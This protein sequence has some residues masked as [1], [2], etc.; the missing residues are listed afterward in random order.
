MWDPLV[1]ALFIWI[2]NLSEYVSQVMT[3][4]RWIYCQFFLSNRLWVLV[5]TLWC[6]YHIEFTVLFRCSVCVLTY[7]RQKIYKRY[8]SRLLFSFTESIDVHISSNFTCGWVEDSRSYFYRETRCSLSPLVHCVCC[9]QIFAMLQICCI[10]GMIDDCT[11]YAFIKC[12]AIGF[13]NSIH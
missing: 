13:M 7:L 3:C 4:I 6:S 9:G 10:F 5:I 12:N 11:A 1:H 2:Q 8:I